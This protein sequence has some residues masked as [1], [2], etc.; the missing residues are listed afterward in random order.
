MEPWML[1][2]IPAIGL[3]MGFATA[4]VGFTSKIEFTL[5]T[6]LYLGVAVAAGL[7]DWNGFVDFGRFIGLSAL[8]GIFTG[9][10]Q[11]TLFENYKKNNPHYAE[12]MPESQAAAWK[13]FLPFAAF[14]GA[15]FGAI[16]AG[17]AW[18]ISAI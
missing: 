9:V 6:G 14:M 17:I 2:W 3:F 15:L 8:G 5:W 18:G 1:V 16:F 13:S 12:Q 10:L 11:A 7:T 4:N